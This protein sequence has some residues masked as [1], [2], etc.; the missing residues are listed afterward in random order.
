MTRKIKY[1]RKDLKSP[2]EF[3]STLSRATLWMKEN[4]TTVIVALIK[5]VG[6]SLGT[7]LGLI[8]ESIEGKSFAVLIPATTNGTVSALSKSYNFV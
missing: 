1:T 6:T 2:D 4:R 5:K 8:T 3:I 7:K